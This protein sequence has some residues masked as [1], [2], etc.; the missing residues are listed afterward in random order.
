MT[1]R[2]L[3]QVRQQSHQFRSVT[4]AAVI[5]PPKVLEPDKLYLHWER[6]YWLEWSVVWIMLFWPFMYLKNVEYSRSGNIFTFH[7]SIKWWDLSMKMCFSRYVTEGWFSN[8][9]ILYWLLFLFWQLM[10]LIRCVDNFYHDENIYIMTKAVGLWGMLSLV[11][12]MS[13]YLSLMVVDGPMY[14]H[15]SNV[16]S[17]L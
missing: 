6:M 15:L 9:M 5:W 13:A 7:L 2:F 16:L 11:A 3:S 12:I 1:D 4:C 17:S 14:Y 10:L 8:M